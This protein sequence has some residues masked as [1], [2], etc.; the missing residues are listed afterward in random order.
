[1]SGLFLLP[2]VSIAIGSVV[3][4]AASARPF[5]APLRVGERANE[6]AGG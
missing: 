6:R 2:M 3:A 5:D 4:V 1:M